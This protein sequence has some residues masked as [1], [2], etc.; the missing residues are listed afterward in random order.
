MGYPE[1]IG[2]PR[3]RDA[4]AAWCEITGEKIRIPTNCCSALL[5]F[6]SELVPIDPETGLAPVPVQLYGYRQEFPEAKLEID[7]LMT[8]L[9]GQPFA[10]STI[11]S[12]G[13][14]KTIDIGGG[15][16]ILTSN[17]YLADELREFGF[18]P[19]ILYQ[20]LQHALEN[21]HDTIMMKKWEYEEIENSAAKYV[22]RLPDRP[23]LPWRF[24]AKTHDIGAICRM[25][26][27]AN[28]KVSCNYPPLPGVTDPGAIQ[29]GKEVINIW[30]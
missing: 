2:F 12:F 20:S 29:W 15:G 25:A 16:A 24:V 4:L 13:Y 3:A 14:A 28:Y 30:K 26:E 5:P 23:T 27:L 9:L 18:F 21:I 8:G 11:V 10:E 17:K 22:E 6:A 19:P 1:V 7:P